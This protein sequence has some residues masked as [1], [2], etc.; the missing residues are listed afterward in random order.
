MPDNARK[1]YIAHYRK[2]RGFTQEELGEM[3]GTSQTQIM[4]LE[5]GRRKFT[6]EWAEKMAQPLLCSTMELFYGPEFAQHPKGAK[7][8]KLLDTFGDLPEEEQKNFLLMMEA[9]ASKWRG[10]I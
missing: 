2:A 8:K 5:T 6:M 9:V 3:L 10:K 4:R 1:N 7:E